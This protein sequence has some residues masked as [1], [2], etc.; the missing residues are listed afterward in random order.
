MVFIK[1]V[2]LKQYD[3]GSSGYYFVTAVCNYRQNFFLNKENLVKTELLDLAQKIPGLS[4]D[5]YSVMP[6]HIHVIFILKECKLKLG[7]IVRRFKAK[8]SRSFKNNV[9]QPNYYEHVIRNEQA[10]NR[11]REYILKNPEEE[12]IEFKQFYD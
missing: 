9:W 6:N 4:L 2:R 10:L 7:E 1:D 11:M 3:Y 8:V 12:I 5:F